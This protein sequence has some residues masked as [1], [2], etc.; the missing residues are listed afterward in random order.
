MIGGLLKVVLAEAD[1]LLDSSLSSMPFKDL[2][3]LGDIL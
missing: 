3:L 1:F 2:V